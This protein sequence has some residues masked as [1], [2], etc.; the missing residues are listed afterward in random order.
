MIICEVQGEGGFNFVA[1]HTPVVTK[2]KSG[3][4]LQAWRTFVD[5][6]SGPLFS[7][8]LLVITLIGVTF[9]TKTNHNRW[10][11]YFLGFFAFFYAISLAHIPRLFLTDLDA[12]VLHI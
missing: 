8:I 1:S 7:A 2:Y 4:I 11:Y 12:S 10:R 6:I 5:I 3:V 9:L